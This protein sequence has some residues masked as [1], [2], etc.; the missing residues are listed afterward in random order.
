MLQ[1]Q[2]H[3]AVARGPVFPGQLIPQRIHQPGLAVGVFPEL[4]IDRRINGLP[5]GRFVLPPQRCGF[6][7]TQIT[8]AQRLGLDIE[9]RTA[10]DD[11]V[12]CRMD[13]VI[14][15]IAYATQDD[16]LRKCC[17]AL[18]IAGTNLAQQRD[19]RVADQCVHFVEEQHRRTWVGGGPE[20]Q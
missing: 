19:Q 14:P 2:R 15:H 11:F 18:G 16:G 13:A 8:Q 1:R 7:A 10:G 9:R 17:G 5:G 3:A 4:R 6:V 12:M 20:S